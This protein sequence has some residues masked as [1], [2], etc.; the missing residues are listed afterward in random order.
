MLKHLFAVTVALSLATTTSL[1]QRK[2]PG[3]QAE[4]AA[5]TERG[6][7]LFGYDT[8]AWHATD[9]IL[10][11]KPDET[12]ISQY[13]A[14]SDGGN[15]VVA[16]GRFS[17]KR[18]KFMIAYEAIQGASAT[19]F[20]I[21]TYDPVKEDSGFFLNAAKAAEIAKADFTGQSRPYNVAILPAPEG[22]FFVYV[23]PAQ[24]TAGIYPHGGDMRYLISGDGSKIVERRQMHKAILEVD[25]S[26]NAEGGFHIAVMDEIPED[27]DVFFVLT[28]KPRVPEWILTSKYAYLVSPDG[29]IRYLMPAETFLKLNPRE[30]K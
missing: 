11:T 17:D 20:T 30:Q 12:R 10:A 26:G 5:I 27:T 22:R 7:L 23:M 25:F 19:E 8:A 28:R 4:L 16:F 15:W 1:A 6:K 18:D 2:E 14:K 24:T 21:K 9:T 3:S 29:S 13:V